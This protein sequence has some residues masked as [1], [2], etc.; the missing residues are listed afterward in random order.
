MAFGLLYDYL[1]GQTIVGWGMPDYSAGVSLYVGTQ[2][3]PVDSV[4]FVELLGANNS[5]LTVRV[6][7]A[8]V[9]Y[10]NN[11]N[12]Y[13]TNHGSEIII[14]KGATVKIEGNLNYG[15]YYPLKGV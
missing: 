2:T 3:I 15:I 9:F 6:N 4:A 7:D 5:Y 14:P 8:V 11:S 1:M 13:W 10:G 12:G